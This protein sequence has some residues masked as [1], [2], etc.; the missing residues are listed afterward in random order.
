MKIFTKTKAD[1]RGRVGNSIALLLSIYFPPEPGGGSSAAWNRAHILHKMGYTVFVLC[2]FPS[3]P[4]GKLLDMK[5]ERKFFFI[6]T[7]E[8]F[9][10]IRIRQPLIESAGYFNRFIIF[11]SFIF[12]TLFYMPKI[13]RIT[14]KIS[15]VYAIA[16]IIF[17]SISGFIY[18]KLTRSFFVYEASD[19]W[20]EQLVAYKTPLL[21][22]IIKV[23]KVVAKLCYAVP[24]II[25]AISELAAQHI[26]KEYRPK[27]LVYVMP[28]GVDVNKFQKRSKA[29]CRKELIYNKVLPEKLQDRFI[30][31]YAGLIS[32]G[33]EVENL[34]YAANKLKSKEEIIF[35]IIGD[36]EE[37]QKLESIKL[38]YNLD[39]FYIIPF[40][41]RDTM[42]CIISAVDVCII[43]L[44]SQPIFDVDVPTKFYEY[45]ACCKPLI[46]ISQGELARIIKSANIGRS[47]KSSDIDGLVSNIND[48][49][50]SPALLQSMENNCYVTLQRFSLDTLASNF[51]DMLKKNNGVKVIDI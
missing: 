42:P 46:G 50:S 17:S 20:P 34:A 33:T 31:L 13:L 29:D 8:P 14:G 38:E 43:S 21:S 45:L 10:V 28:I 41:A 22:I 1:G 39:N 27:A 5:Y 51:S 4:S 7:M 30:I 37:R 9:T 44:S 6:E 16:P 18:S 40:Q 2:G 32:K 49:K 24:D 47:V 3:Y 35:L 12:L 15:L 23:G 36:G 48:F 19:L 25:I 11:L 26:T